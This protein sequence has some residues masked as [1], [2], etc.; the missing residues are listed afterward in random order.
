MSIKAFRILGWHF[1]CVVHQLGS[2]CIA[3]DPY[4]Y[5]TFYSPQTPKQCQEKRAFIWLFMMSYSYNMYFI[6]YFVS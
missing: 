3:A 6:R 1:G 4:L 2:V 5:E